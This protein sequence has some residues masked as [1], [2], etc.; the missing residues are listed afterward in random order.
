MSLRNSIFAFGAVLGAALLSCKAGADLPEVSEAA[1]PPLPPLQ[2][3]L[4]K[5]EVIGIEQVRRAFL[6]FGTNE[7]VFVIPP[8]FRMDASDSGKVV[9]SDANYDFYLTF[10]VANPAAGLRAAQ[11]EACRELLV[12]QHPNV[13]ILDEFFQSAANRGGPAFDLQWDN[14]SGAK[15][16]SRVAFIPS[17]AGTLEFSL[18]SKPDKFAQGKTFFNLLLSTFLS[19]EGGKI[20]IIPFS[21]KS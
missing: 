16:A 13:K 2:A 21:D 7:F 4:R 9:L 3:N 15:Q 6:T 12:K 19:N 8:G 20:E 5:G 11:T 10:R 14:T 1:P 17:A 18:L